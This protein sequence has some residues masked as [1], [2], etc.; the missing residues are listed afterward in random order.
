M[1]ML[2]KG[3]HK[4]VHKKLDPSTL[5]KLLACFEITMHVGDISVNHL[6][7]KIYNLNFDPLE[8]GSHYRDPQLKWVKLFIFSLQ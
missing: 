1:V 5:D 7:A 4:K 2:L 8:I 3:R 6:A